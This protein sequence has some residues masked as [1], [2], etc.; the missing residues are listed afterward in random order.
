MVGSV[1]AIVASLMAGGAWFARGVELDL[2]SN[3]PGADVVLDGKPLGRTGDRGGT[4]ALPHLARGRHTLSLTHAGFDEWS[5]PIS[6][7]WFELSH[8]LTVALTV[9]SFPLTV[10][11]NPGRA[12]IQL[13]AHDAGASDSNGN[14]VIEKVPRGQH[15]VTVILDGYP[16]RSNTLW[17]AGP[18]SI[19]FDLAAAAVAA[20][21]EVASHLDRA[22]S[23][24]QQRQYDAAIVECDE[25]LR[26]A[27]TNDQAARLKT[28]I[29]QT[30]SILGNQ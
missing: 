4:L 1:V 23:L 11:T 24:Y 7:S 29:Q 21:S 12:K 25:A 18:S 3:P 19:S 30:K 5:Q 28:Q 10:L 6:L 15:M 22:Q 13:D 16:S 2:V 20:E 14:F 9:Q 26:L 8:P 27:P 17:V